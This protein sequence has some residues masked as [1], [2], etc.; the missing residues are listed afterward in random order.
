MRL[1]LP[2]PFSGCFMLV[3]SLFCYCIS[4]FQQE[5]LGRTNRRLSLIRHGPH[6]KRRV[7]QF[8]Y[9]CVC[10]RYRGNVLPSRCLAT[11]G[12]FVPSRCLEAIRGFLPSRCQVTIGGTFTEPLPSNVKGLFPEPL[13]RNDRGDTQTYTHAGTHR[14]Q[15]DLISLLYFLNKKSRLKMHHDCY[16]LKIA[17]FWDVIPYFPVHIH[18]RNG[19][20]CCL[21]S[22]GSKY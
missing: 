6:I 16:V 21:C 7:Q 17:V 15:R 20:N 18:K 12:G 22:Q 19:G 4:L 9:C 3:S 2:L 8:F 11:I 14:Q 13:T 10:I 5:V 1:C